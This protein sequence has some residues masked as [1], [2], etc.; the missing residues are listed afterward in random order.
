MDI[1]NGDVSTYVPGD[2]WNG[3]VNELD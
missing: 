3:L 1:M 2:Y